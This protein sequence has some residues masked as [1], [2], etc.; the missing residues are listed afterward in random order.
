MTIYARHFAM[1]AAP[2]CTALIN[3]QQALDSEHAIRMP[4]Y[5]RTHHLPPLLALRRL[6]PGRC[7]CRACGSWCTLTI[8]SRCRSLRHSILLQHRSTRCSDASLARPTGAWHPAMYV[9]RALGSQA[10]PNCH[11]RRRGLAADGE[12]LLVWGHRFAA[13]LRVDVKRGR[14]DAEHMTAEVD[15]LLWDCLPLLA[16]LDE[17]VTADTAV[18]SLGVRV[19]AKW[20]THRCIFASRL[21]LASPTTLWT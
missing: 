15:D 16:S 9:W 13:L 4:C 6:C 10:A 5:S 2:S 21:R 11:S 19:Q 7:V 14:L 8:A 3:G 20:C 18:R 12:K 17:V 1:R